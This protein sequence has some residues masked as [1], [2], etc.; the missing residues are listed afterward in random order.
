MTNIIVPREG[1]VWQHTNGNRYVVRAI[2]NEYGT[3]F[4]RYPV[5]VVYKGSTNGIMWSRPLSDWHRSMGYV[6]GDYTFCD[7]SKYGIE[8]SH[9]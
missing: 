1:S 2:T 3:D 9:E 4:V 7:E 6:S 5:T 8:S